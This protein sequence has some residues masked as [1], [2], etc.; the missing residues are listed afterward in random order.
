[1]N[2]ARLFLIS[3]SLA[4]WNVHWVS[5]CEERTLV[6]HWL[7]ARRSKGAFGHYATDECLRC[8]KKQRSPGITC[9][10]LRKGRCR[11]LYTN[12]IE[13]AWQFIHC[14]CIFGK[15]IE[16]VVLVA[17][18][19]SCGKCWYYRLRYGFVSCSAEY[20]IP[21]QLWYCFEFVQNYE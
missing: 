2:P 11:K 13:F 18:V 19:R 9:A 5:N 17:M 8:E 12:M 4:K 20:V 3:R 6:N 21:T 7:L 15:E 1:M 10:D 16:K 14:I